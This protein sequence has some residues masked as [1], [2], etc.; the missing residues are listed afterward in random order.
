MCLTFL[1]ARILTV[2][3]K[4]PSP[5]KSKKHLPKNSKKVLQN[6]ATPECHVEGINLEFRDFL[7]LRVDFSN[8]ISRFWLPS[9]M[10]T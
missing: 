5:L 2:Q 3:M 1:A 4:R 8:K 7:S 10:H 9:G 6:I